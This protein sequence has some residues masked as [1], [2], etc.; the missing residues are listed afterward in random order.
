MRKNISL[1]VFIF[2]LTLFAF[3]LN[4]CFSPWTGNG[5]FSISVGDGSGRTAVPWDS[6][7]QIEDLEHTITISGGPGPQQQTTIKGS[8]KVSFSVEPGRWHI[9][10]EAY[11]TVA[12]AG[13]VLVAI[14]STDADIKP[15]NNGVITIHMKQPPKPKVATPTATP[16]P[17][18]YATTQHV[19]LATTTPDAIIY[20][21]T[22]G[23]V[24][25]TASYQY[26]DSDSIG[27]EISAPTATGETSKTTILKAIA[28]KEGMNDSNILTAEYTIDTSLIPVNILLNC[29]DGVLSINGVDHSSYNIPG[30][31]NNPI[32]GF[33]TYTPTRTGYIFKG[34]ETYDKTISFDSTTPLTAANGVNVTGST[35]ALT[36]YAKWEV[37]TVT[38][39]LNGNGGNLPNNFTNPITGTYGGTVSNL[40]SLS[41]NTPTRTG[42]TFAGWSKSSTATTGEFTS[43]TTLTTT[44]GVNDSGNPATLTLY[45]VWTA[46]TYTVTFNKNHTDANGWTEASPTTKTVTTPA[47]TV[48][49]LPNPP[50]RV[51]YKFIGWF[52]ES[53]ASFTA[54]T[55]VSSSITV[56][57]QWEYTGGGTSENPFLVSDITTLQKVGTGTDGWTLSA[58]YEQTANIAL[59]NN[60]TPIG[61]SSSPFTGTF[62]GKGY[63][64]SGLSIVTNEYDDGKNYGLF[65]Y[66][67]TN[68]I[69]KNV[70]LTLVY[71]SGP[72][73][74]AST[75][76][77]GSVGCIA[78][79]NQGTINN[80]S[81][82]NS[83]GIREDYDGSVIGG[84]G[85]I[86]GVNHGT[87]QKCYTTL[88]VAGIKYVGGVVGKNSGTVQYCY[89]TG[90]VSGIVATGS[91]YEDV[92]GVVGYNSGTVQYCYATG[93][94]YGDYNVGGVVGTNTVSVK[95]CYSTSDITVESGNGGGVVGANYGTVDNCYAT[96]VIESGAWYVGSI[97]GC[98]FEV[99]TV[100]NCVA[101]SP[102]IIS[103]NMA[104]R[105]GDKEDGSEI[106][107]TYSNNFGRSDMKYNG[108]TWNGWVEE[109]NGIDGKNTTSSKWSNSSW[110]QT[111]IG[112]NTG[113]CWDFSVSSTK[114]PTL[115]NM[116]GAA[117]NPVIKE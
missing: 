2:I 65:N 70:N 37:K 79:I 24:P 68:G 81:V 8:K 71:I 29:L 86:A 39:T 88:T 50:T 48:G 15:G 27:I 77:N 52:N 69:V 33:D 105:I 95:H 75:P 40:P 117:Q 59:I 100:K 97:I 103:T 83:S 1:L 28:V 11:R 73:Q 101:L 54:S 46:N 107:V 113:S 72:G 42:Y 82:T 22:D 45:A 44:N 94:V 99:S 18:T 58:Y 90:D 84:V 25:T 85:G 93:Y 20:Y 26:D 109:G 30:T 10:V 34:W 19:F 112:F 89:A 7:I 21:T 111:D 115:L 96:G 9:N 4:S 36:L 38:V 56:L 32:I 87:V 3:M 49:T 110:W 114:G 43:T 80:C 64:I 92:G 74:H 12:G 6:S 16:L 62:D 102:N 47:T 60:W 41:A 66:I 116:P 67:D 104:G 76:P 31:L 17:S 106:I 57:A 13:S 5:T 108:A 14:G 23:T 91:T 51:G 35:A 53:G 55:T 78:G 61:T 98:M 63:T